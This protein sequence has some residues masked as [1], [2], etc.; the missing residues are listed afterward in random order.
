MSKKLVKYSPKVTTTQ[1]IVFII[2]VGA[3]IWFLK[4]KNYNEETVSI[5]RD[6]RGRIA[7]MIVNRSVH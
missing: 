5:Q 6:G 3:L 4:S 7:K 1:L 2:V